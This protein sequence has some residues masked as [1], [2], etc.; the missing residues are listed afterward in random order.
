MTAKPVGSLVD[1]DCGCARSPVTM[2]CQYRLDESFTP[3]HGT[4]AYPMRTWIWK[5]L[6]SAAE[7]FVKMARTVWPPMEILQG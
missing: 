3:V 7:L 4:E 1:S 2:R 6:P 5:L